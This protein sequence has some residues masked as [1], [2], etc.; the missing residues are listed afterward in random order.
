MDDFVNITQNDRG[1]LFQT[2]PIPNTFIKKSR[3]EKLVRLLNT[4]IDCEILLYLPV[5]W[6][7]IRLII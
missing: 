6:K 4:F 3:T 7:A 1:E 5:I 2:V